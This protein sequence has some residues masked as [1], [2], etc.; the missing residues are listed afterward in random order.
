MEYIINDIF[1]QILDD[2]EHIKPELINKSDYHDLDLIINYLENGGKIVTMASKE[3]CKLCGEVAGSRNYFT[4]G[5]W[6]WPIWIKH[7][8]VQHKLKLPEQ[9]ILYIRENNFKIM[10]VNLMRKIVNQEIDYDVI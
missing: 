3:D 1:N 9:F 2:K 8:L 4:D 7:Y 6:I 5:K 10:E